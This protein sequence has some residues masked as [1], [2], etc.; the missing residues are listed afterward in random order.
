MSVMDV[1]VIS[2]QCHSLLC[3]CFSFRKS[4]I[5]ARLDLLMG[6]VVYIL[7]RERKENK[8]LPFKAVAWNNEAPLDGHRSMQQQISRLVERENT[9]VGNE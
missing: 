9:W 7:L 6:I 3:V 5:I 8:F 1:K 4:W 2:Q